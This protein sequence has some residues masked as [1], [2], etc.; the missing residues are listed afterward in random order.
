MAAPYI[1]TGS[2]I[3]F[4]REATFGTKP[5]AFGGSGGNANPQFFG[6]TNQDID[7]PDLELDIKQYRSFGAGRAYHSQVKGR[8]VFNGSLPL[9]L[10]NARLLYYIMGAET[11][12]A[13]VGAGPKIHK[14]F[15]VEGAVMPSLTWGGILTGQSGSPDFMRSFVG[16]VFDG[17]SFSAPE[18][19]ELTLSID[20]KSIDVEDEQTVTPSLWTQP[21][22]SGETPYMFYDRDA[23]IRVAGT[24]DFTSAYSS[25]DPYTYSNRYTGSREWMRV[26]SFNFGIRNNLKE[27]YVYR[28]SNAQNPLEFIT[29]FP[30]FDLTIQVVPTGK[31]SGDESAT[32]DSVYDLLMAEGKF[33]VLVPFRK[34]NTDRLDF[35]FRQC[36]VKSA[37]HG[38]NTDGNEV[39]V[40][41]VLS[42]ETFHAISYDNLGQY[43]TDVA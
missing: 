34:S 17:C 13:A 35:A 7:F 15:P 18:T 8:R 21:A 40:D 11:F 4:G 36:M 29:G 28:S 38:L 9:V 3:A 16:T 31:L 20:T 12:T 32:A 19:G 23:H 5:A 14:M 24:Y 10:T 2:R 22:G 42:P 27:Q 33:D 39:N 1:S 25:A 26:K 30:E 37:K 6:I 43:A 41:V